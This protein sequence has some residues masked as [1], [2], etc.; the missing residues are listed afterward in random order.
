MTT[1]RITGG[2]FNP[3]ENKELLTSSSLP[4]SS[5]VLLMGDSFHMRGSETVAGR[6][7]MIYFEAFRN[8]AIGQFIEVA[9]EENVPP[10]PFGSSITLFSAVAHP[11][12]TCIS[13]IN[14]R[15]EAS[16]PNKFIGFVNG[17]CVT[18]FSE[19]MI[20]HGA[21]VATES[22][23]GAQGSRTLPGA[24]ISFI[25]QGIAVSFPSGIMTLTPPTSIDFLGTIGNC[26]VIHK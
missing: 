20:M 6:T 13:L 18:K 12:P 23:L 22:R 11:K 3:V 4:S 5:N 26:A 10:T 1:P 8:E 24:P 21:K 7:E 17:G 16:L 9:M 19:S 14:L 2:T 25:G 15:P